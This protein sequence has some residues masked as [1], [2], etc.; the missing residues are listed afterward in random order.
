MTNLREPQALEDLKVLDLGGIATAYGTRLLADF[1]ADVVLVE[2]P[3]GD[4]TRHL[5]PYAESVDEPENSL[6]FLAFNTNK[7]SIVLDINEDQDRVKLLNIIRNMD[8]V[9]E[10]FKPGYLASIGLSY[11]EIK[12]INPSVILC[13]ITPFGQTGPFSSYLGGDL[14]AE[15]MGGIMKLQGDPS[16]APSM[17]PAWLS[18]SLSGIHSVTGVMQAIFARIKNGSGQ[19]VD[20]SMQESAAHILFIVSQYG[21]NGAIAQRPG[22]GAGGGSGMFECEDGYIG[23]SPIMEPQ[24]ERLVKWMEEPAL[25][26]P[27]FLDL[28]VRAENADFINFLVNEFTKKFTVDEFV[29]KAQSLRIPAAPVS[30]PAGLANNAHLLARDYFKKIDH[31]IIGEY[32]LPGQPGNFS[33][34]PSKISRPAPFLGQHTEEI[35]DQYS[36]VKHKKV[37]T[38]NIGVGESFLPLEGVRI[39]DLTRIWVGPYGTRQLADF[40]AEVIKIESS[41]FDAASRTTGLSPMHPE[42]NRNKMSITVDL[43]HEEGQKIVKELAKKS[44]ALTENYAAGALSKWG[45]DYDNLKKD[46]PGIV[47]LS[48]PGWGSTGPFNG[49]V[50]FGLQAQTAS[51]VTYLWGHPDSPPDLRCGAYYADFFVGAQSAFMLEAALYYKQK[52]GIGQRIEISQVEAQANALGVPILN[53]FSNG[54][55]EKPVAN[56]RD[57]SAPHGVYP[58]IGEDQWCAI[59]CRN[60]EEW[61]GFIKGLTPEN[62]EPPEWL[63]DPD[64]ATFEGRLRNRDKLDSLITQW[65]LTLTPRQVMFTLQKNGVAAT[66]VQ[67]TEDVYNDPHLNA[68]GFIVNIEHPEPQWGTVGHAKFSAQLSMTPGSIRKGAPG[69]GQHNQYVLKELLGYSSSDIEDLVTSK[70][71]V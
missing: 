3:L 25:E 59:S 48:M 39:T 54:I 32:T 24:W 67:T 10:S 55:D 11:E 42:L 37:I 69:L 17:S 34:T 2:P 36:N 53:Y 5:A 71:L 49:H 26:D 4:A 6:T 28:R 29:E 15:A 52:T 35:I 9:Y 16:K 45:L 31:P 50:L 13:S 38:P 19:H 14:H 56:M 44:D 27:M 7:R 8:V 46:N 66:V 43:H 65:T 23:L 58:C 61:S 30:T 62:G 21:Y 51:G 64:F 41:L 57:H 22:A 1:G 40:G 47:Y 63:A 12:K 20:V 70:I 18:Y 68:R 60:E 33:E